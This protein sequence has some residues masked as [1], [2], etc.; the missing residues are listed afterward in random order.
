MFD[1]PGG[2]ILL[3]LA[4]A[5]PVATC[6]EPDV[7]IHAE[8][9]RAAAELLIETHLRQDV[10]EQQLS[11]V[12]ARQFM[13]ALDPRRMHFL[14]S[15]A[16]EFVEKASRL[17]ADA[18]K[19]KADFAIL[20]ATRFRTRVDS[21]AALIAKLLDEDH[22]FAIDEEVRL[23]HRD[24]A[25]TKADCKERWRLRIKYELLM[26]NPGD[27]DDEDSRRF[28]RARYARIERHVKSLT[29][30]QITSLYIDSLAKSFDPH[31]AYSDEQ[32]LV[33]FRTSHIPNY[34]L[35]LNLAH[36]QGDLWIL[37]S[38][39]NI[40]GEFRSLAGC[41]IVAIRL[42]GKEPIHLTGLTDGS[43]L[44]TIISSIAELGLAKRVILDVDNPKCGKRMV[45]TCDRWL[46]GR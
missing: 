27:L 3:L 26:E 39:Y 17:L 42:E 16:D 43:A 20:A 1:A 19:G 40:H 14:A 24:Y 44:R 30:S 35:G 8:V 7:G 22:D 45:A 10:D 29:Q 37:P 13:A 23:E 2:W 36:R 21:N 15:D 32:F 12:W 41:R 25:P 46:P 28:L 6:A 4:V 9:V 11:Q 38:P 5:C 34:T 33:M 31:S 18:H